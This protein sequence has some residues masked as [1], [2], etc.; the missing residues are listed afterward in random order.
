MHILM[1][2][3]DEAVPDAVDKADLPRRFPSAAKD[4]GLVSS[5]KMI[6]GAHHGLEQQGCTKDD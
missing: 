3:D 1:A 5:G 2:G 4:E 6:E